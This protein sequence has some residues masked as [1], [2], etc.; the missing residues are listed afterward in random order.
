MKQSIMARLIGGTVLLVATMAVLG[1]CF[2]AGA[3]TDGIV[4]RDAGLFAGAA[5]RVSD[6][7]ASLQVLA[8]GADPA[9]QVKRLRQISASA[10][11]IDSMLAA[12]L[13]SMNGSILY[14]AALKEAAR[15][16]Q[17]VMSPGWS[18]TLQGAVNAVTG[19]GAAGSPGA[20]GSFGLATERVLSDFTRIMR[21]F[22]QANAG[23]GR[24]LT[25]LFASFAVL[26]AIS[27]F[28][29]TFWALL[30]IRRDLR[31]LIVF[32]GGLSQG[33]STP[34]PEVTADGE[35]G[36]LAA[37]L[38]K[39]SSLEAV[40]GRLRAATE[41]VVI[42][43]PAAAENAAKVQESFTSQTQIVKD[44]SRGLSDV[45]Q[46]VK[47]MARSADN[48][49]ISAREG[50]RTVEA[51]LETIQRA[52][53]ATSVLEERTSRIEEVVALI[54]DVADQTELLSL[55]AAIEAA[56]AGEAG[57]G[58]TV[59]AEQVRKLADRSARSASEVA[60][61]AQIMLD[62]VRRV[63]S[64]ARESFRTIDVLRRD[65]QG[66]SQALASVTG[67]SGSAVDGA[68]QTVSALSAA[69]ELGSDTVRRA[70]A[71]TASNTALREE[72]EQVAAIVA[73]LPKGRAPDSE[74]PL[75]GS[76]PPA[77]D[78]LEGSAI[79]HAQSRLPG[80]VEPVDAIEELPA[81]EEELE[82]RAESADATEVEELEP[83]E[84]L[85]SAEELKPAEED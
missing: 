32:S 6:I 14:P 54:G 42:D 69:L 35:V 57:R 25:V 49:L 37:Q 59:V 66:M 82:G 60:D 39:L 67:L 77:A 74:K 4:E 51:S 18:Q 27:L 71:I 7:S 56:R 30:S 2:A 41:R 79:V 36:E 5:Q 46:A 68:A 28:G 53:D 13:S 64:D 70:Q 10:L 58:F 1:I 21:L 63:A 8:A 65:L 72:V 81:A 26:G 55:N 22:D 83:V 9:G 61:L 52:I 16:L 3:A 31:K 33:D 44:V 76:E 29:F 48:S 62:A 19:A 34:P 43:F 47:E 85:E 17:D 80:R 75:L 20:L 23:M 24:T 50:A 40:A 84:E 15:N 73:N 38:R 45:A 12:A 78:S 11:E